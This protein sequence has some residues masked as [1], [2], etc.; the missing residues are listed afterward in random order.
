MGFN[1]AAELRCERFAAEA[2]I[3]MFYSENVAFTYTFNWRKKSRSEGR[4]ETFLTTSNHKMVFTITRCLIRFENLLGSQILSEYM[5]KII[6][7]IKYLSKKN[8]I[9]TWNIK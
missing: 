1:I 4:T 2:L 8:I 7:T 5:I 3:L 6:N 9:L